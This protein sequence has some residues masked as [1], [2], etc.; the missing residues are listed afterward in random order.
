MNIRPATPPDYAT[1]L[2]LNEQAIPHVNLI[3]ETELCELANASCYFKVAQHDSETVGFLLALAEGA[4]YDS[5]NYRW[6]ANKFRQFVYVDRIIVDP[7]H[8]GGG[9]ARRLYDDLFRR[10]RTA[11][12]DTVA[13]E[14]NV[15]PPN[16]GSDAFHERMGFVEMGR[17]ALPASGKTV[18]YLAKHLG[19]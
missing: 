2:Q 17:A 15:D 19:L 14:V 12:H 11:G 1:I 10:A 8:R 6:F 16:P 3:S 7:S 18:R 13:C 9:L 4:S 5:L